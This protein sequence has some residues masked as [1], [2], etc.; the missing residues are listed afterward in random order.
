MGNNFNDQ[1]LEPVELTEKAPTPV[2]DDP[3]DDYEDEYGAWDSNEDNSKAKFF[4][5]TL[6]S[7]MG[8]VVI[9]IIV[10]L[11]RWQ[12]GED[13]VIS[14]GDLT[15]NYDVESEDFHVDF[16]PSTIDGYVDDGENNI[17]I[18]GDAS[19]YNCQDD[20]GIAALVAD[21][22]GANVTALSLPETTIA[23]Q[24]D[25]YT[26]EYAQDAF[27]LYY[28]ISSICGGDMGSYDLM[29][30]SLSYI[31][32]NS[33]YYSYWD[34]IHK[35][36]FN[37]VDTLIIEYGLG[38]YLAK[39]P[40]IGAE[41]Y[42]DQL[43]GLESSVAG[44]LNDCIV[45]LKERFPYMRILIVCPSFC[46]TKDDNGNTIGSDLYNNGQGTLGDYIV[47][48][49]YIAQQNNV[50]FVDNYFGIAFNA[51]TYDGYLTPD[52]QYPNALGRQEIANHIVSF[53][54]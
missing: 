6:I 36:D 52:G 38:D 37:K 4:H 21:A 33:V 7:I 22:T 44:S 32:D 29:Y 41:V 19:I 8:I 49:K 3:Y 16:D 1:D 18:L 12:R 15:E 10:L 34:S 24:E 2:K 51:S 47:N 14:E 45:M 27:N 35:I 26:Q 9:A 48:M 53:L 42:S 54:P 23:L 17:V 5:I 11:A 25:S 43:Y 39:R 20:T 46:L 31:E 28:I 30:D 50:A 13:F 40:L